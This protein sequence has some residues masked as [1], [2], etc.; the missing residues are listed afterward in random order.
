MHK[1]SLVK[2]EK[3]VESV[4]QAIELCGGLSR[5]PAH[6]KVFLKPNIVYWTK[7]VPFPKWGVITTSRVVADVVQLL[8]EH[9]VTDIT[10]GEGIVLTRAGS[11]E[12]AAHAFETLGY[13][14]LAQRYGVKVINTFE[15]PF[16]EVD[17]GE[18]M[19][20][21]YNADAL[22]SDFV[23]TLP[24]MKT[25]AQ[26]MVSLGIKNLKGLID[27][28]SRK[29]CHSADPAR[30]LHHWVARLAEPLPPVLAVLDGIYTA[31]RGPAFDGVM[32]RANLLAASWDVLAADL[33]GARLLGQN[34]AEVPYLAHAAARAG[35]PL[36]LSDVEV[37]GLKVDDEARP[38]QWTFPYNETCTLPLP[39]AKKG[40]SGVS[41]YKYDTSMCTY[42]S[43]LNGVVLTSIAMAWRGQPWDE[44]EVLTGKMMQPK[45]GAKHTVLLGKCMYQAHKDNPDIAHMIAVK[46]C[47]PDPDKVAE[48][49]HEAGIMVDPNIFRGMDRLPGMYMQRYQGKPEFEEALFQVA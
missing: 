25:H 5:I 7:S 31:E 1:V 43:G 38:H 36:D 40:M 37:A 29:R 24:V 18:D 48:A 8:A 16:E 17:L 9:G 10:I 11:K 3:P 41:C 13:A 46:G 12:V 30:D 26:T 49:L 42:C 39:M 15:R 33:V 45:P 47:P 27:V 14:K 23:V 34:P 4:R 21:S 6:A 32:H 35:R 22:H 20:L 19:K 28:N 44:V 2:Y